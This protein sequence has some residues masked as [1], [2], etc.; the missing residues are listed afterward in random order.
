MVLSSVESVMGMT[1][2]V[3]DF[4]GRYLIGISFGENNSMTHC[5]WSLVLTYIT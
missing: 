5:N 2:M 3:A 1:H 4:D